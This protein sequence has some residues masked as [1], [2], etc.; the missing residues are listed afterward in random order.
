MLLDLLSLEV[1]PPTLV[2]PDPV[3]VSA[4]VTAPG[5]YSVLTLSPAV[6]AVPFAS[7]LATVLPGARVV[8]LGAVVL[9][10]ATVT[11]LLRYT[12]RPSALAIPFDVAVPSVRAARVLLPSATGVSF[13]AVSPSVRAE[14]LL[15]P[16]AV[17]IGFQTTALVLLKGPVVLHPVAFEVVVA[18]PVVF[19]VR[20][21]AVSDFVPAPA[22][23]TNT[24]GPSPLRYLARSW[25]KRRPIS[26]KTIPQ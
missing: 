7:P 10:F 23:R 9:S 16:V 22:P 25:P 18:A 1:A 5:V 12:V 24:R 6:V 11:P 19:I 8:S 3:I 20:P 4:V 2:A 26:A 14:R 15:A 13:A 17:P 21:A